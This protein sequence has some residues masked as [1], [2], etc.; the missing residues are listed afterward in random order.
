MEV[1]S[2]ILFVQKFLAKEL[3]ERENIY[4]EQWLKEDK[5]NSELYYQLKDIWSTP[6][7]TPKKF[8]KDK[9]FQ[10]HLDVINSEKSSVHLT[11]KQTPN[12]SNQ[13]QARVI[14]LSRVMWASAAMFTLVIGSWFLISNDT[15]IIQTISATDSKQIAS[16][17]DGTKVNL[18]QGARLEV[19]ESKNERK[20]KLTGEAYFEVTK[21]DG[22]PFVV[23]TDD[24]IITVLGTSF[25]VNT[26]ENFCAVK[27]GKVEVMVDGQKVVLTQNQKVE[28]KNNKL[29]VVTNNDFNQ[30]ETWLKDEL[31]FINE[32][33]DKVVEKLGKHFNIN[34]ILPQTK[35][36]SSCTFTSGSLKSASIEDVLLI[37]QLTYELEYSKD[38]SGNFKVTKVKCK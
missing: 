24:A 12:T 5:E 37:L 20:V 38:E 17:E 32:P 33:F 31:K 23:N 14:S 18:N 27:E 26:L 19:I 35:D 2:K 11:V 36:W 21:Q 8:N 15:N 29:D 6:A 34:F 30:S 13:N 7:P 3:N 9:A 25:T 16:L 28:F 22:K 4:F 10:R 1:T